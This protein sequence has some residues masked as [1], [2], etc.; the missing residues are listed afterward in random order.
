MKLKIL[1]PHQ[2]FLD[3]EVKQIVAQGADG[4]F[5][6]K[7]KHIDFVSALVPGL[8][9]VINTAGKEEFYAINDGIL[10]KYGRE[11]RVSAQNAIGGKSLEEL[12]SAVEEE[13]KVIDEQEQAAR[14]AIAKLE[15]DTIRK[16]MDLGG[17]AFE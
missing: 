11:V 9:M 1:L 8:F 6:L 4:F 14:A 16:F 3:T 13:F 2:V 17:K 5:C 12:K 7:P 10:V 15:F